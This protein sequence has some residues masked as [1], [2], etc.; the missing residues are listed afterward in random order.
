MVTPG[1]LLLSGGILQ[2]GAR[3]SAVFR[4]K[5]Q[6]G[7]NTQTGKGAIKSPL[8]IIA[9]A[10]PSRSHSVQ[11]LDWFGACFVVDL[12]NGNLPDLNVLASRPTLVAL[13][14]GRKTTQVPA[15]LHNN[16]GEPGLSDPQPPPRPPFSP[17][18]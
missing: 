2:T 9:P 8:E 11:G 13:R 15:S 1:W 4:A 7:T 14:D 12:R 6:G 5:Q 17:S 18:P 3:W 10:R 16:V